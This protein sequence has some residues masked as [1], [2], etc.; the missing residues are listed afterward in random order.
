[1]ENLQID[2]L[3]SKKRIAGLEKQEVE[4][5][6]HAKILALNPNLKLTHPISE[7]PAP[8]PASNQNVTTDKLR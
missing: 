8:R 7:A 2:R 4:P 1:M 6:Y 5:L 3:N